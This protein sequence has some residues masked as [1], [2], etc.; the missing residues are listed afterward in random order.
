VHGTDR[1]LGKKD[2]WRGLASEAELQQ[3]DAETTAQA[4]EAHTFAQNSPWP[5]PATVAH[6]VFSSGNPE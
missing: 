6:N 1:P 2:D 5:D 4:V 3:I